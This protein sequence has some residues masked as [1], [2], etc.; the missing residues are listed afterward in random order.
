MKITFIRHAEVIEEYQGRYN[1]HIDIPLSQNGKKQAQELA[2]SLQDKKFDKIYCSDLL[3]TRETLEA[4][5]LNQE[6]IFS[7]KLREK[8]WGVHEGKSFEE[9]LNQGIEYHN[10]EQWLNQLDGEEISS[11]I[12]RVKNY[13]NEVI[14]QDKSKNILIV[15]HSGFIKTLISLVEHIS[16]E[17][18]FSIPLPYSSSTLLDRTKM[19]FFSAD[20][21]KLHYP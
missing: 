20:G 7:D 14:L 8:S 18:A 16:L 21:I 3:R 5:K 2:K 17:K 19:T 9:I 1:G 11:Y 4:F 10:F 12:L 13:F 6:T 15:T